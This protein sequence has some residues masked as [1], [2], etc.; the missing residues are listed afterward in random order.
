MGSASL[1]AV[2]AVSRHFLRRRARDKADALERQH[3]DQLY[4]VLPSRRGP[5]RWR[6]Y[7][8]EP[9]DRPVRSS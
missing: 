9:G 5:Y 2:R 6:V 8:L 3:P 7:Q 4:A 1:V